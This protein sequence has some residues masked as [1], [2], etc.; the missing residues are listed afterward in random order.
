M[1]WSCTSYS[2]G[3]FGYL[4]QTTPLLRVWT[5]VTVP[6]STPPPYGTWAGVPTRGCGGSAPPSSLFAAPASLPPPSA[7]FCRPFSFGVGTAFYFGGGGGSY[8]GI[9]VGVSLP[10]D[11]EEEEA[12][13]SDSW[14]KSKSDSNRLRFFAWGALPPLPCLWV[15]GGGLGLEWGGCL[16]PPFFPSPPLPCHLPSPAKAPHPHTP[17][18]LPPPSVPM[19]W[20]FRASRGP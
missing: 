10:E 14:A 6:T 16:P 18:T 15:G 17:T 12:G 4:T 19:K 13:S 5:Q 7:F 9:R 1:R 2:L 3:L 20:A 8:S 11:D